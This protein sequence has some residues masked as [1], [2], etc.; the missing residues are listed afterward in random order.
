MNLR[1]YQ[2]ECIDSV[3]RSFVDH[4]S[5]LA[6]LATGLGKTVIGANLIREWIARGWF[7]RVLWLAHR[8]EL[9][10]QAAQAIRT[11]AGVDV[12]VEMGQSY[13]DHYGFKPP[14]VV[15][16]SVP[17][18]ARARRR[19]RFRP[20]QF[21]LII[22]DEAH[23]ATARTYRAIYHYFRH[24]DGDGIPGNA[25]CRHLGITATPKRSDNLAM[26]RVYDF[27]AYDYGIEPAVQDG[28][29]VPVRQAVVVVADLNLSR[30]KVVAGDYS[31][32]QLERELV[33]D[34]ILHQMAAPSVELIG[35][36][37]ALFFCCGVHQAKCLDEVLRGYRPGSSAFVS[38]ET[39]SEKRR[40][41][42]RSFREGQ[43]QY[44]CNCGVFLEGFDAP[45][46]AFVVMARP[47]K[48]LPLYVQMLG[49]ATRPLPGTVEGHADAG[50][51]KAS[52]AASAKPSATVIDFVGNAQRHGEFATVSAADVLGGDYSD[53]VKQY[54]KSA[55]ADAA[56]SRPIE[57]ALD[58]A[59]AEIELLREEEERKARVVAEV[60]YRVRYLGDGASGP[61]REH[62]PQQRGEPATAKQIGMLV[63]LGVPRHK[64]ER[65]TKQQARGWIGKLMQE[66]GRAS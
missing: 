26:G 17:T 63:F 62:R 56:G 66:K 38:G 21:G 54:A 22:T 48:S 52:I 50:A 2:A 13:A 16:A 10:E 35:D 39:D 64:A 32:D 53:E 30:V 46:T 60:D 14:P 5:V 9:I 44:L 12:S 27:V 23:H 37:Q 8:E 55:L 19:R 40:E 57:D 49:R 42:V 36:R 24:G 1:P 7:G 28:W 51:R 58:R 59:E 25:E 31:P 18:L 3:F 20:E 47:T 34:K 41:I 61:V 29:L 15:L 43:L 45:A 65:V 11:W 33:R 4:R 6:V